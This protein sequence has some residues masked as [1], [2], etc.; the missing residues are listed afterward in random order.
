MEVGGLYLKY[1]SVY[2]GMK[3]ESVFVRSLLGLI[4][5]SLWAC[6]ADKTQGVKEGVIAVKV[7]EELQKGSHNELADLIAGVDI[8]PLETTDSSLLKEPDKLVMDE[9]I[10]YLNRPAKSLHI[11]DREGKFVKALP[12]GRGPGEIYQILDFQMDDNGNLLAL[13]YENLLRYSPEGDYL[14]EFKLLP[15]STYDLNV[16]RFAWLGDNHFYLWQNGGLELEKRDQETYYHLFHM[17]G[18]Q[19]L[20]SNLEAFS[21][22]MGTNRFLHNGENYMVSPTMYDNSI[23]EIDKNGGLQHKYEID[24]GNANV[25]RNQLRPGFSREVR[26][27]NFKRISKFSMGISKVYELGD[28]LYFQFVSNR[29]F[30]F[31]LYHLKEGTVHSSSMND[32][33]IDDQLPFRIIGIDRKEQ[34][35]LAIAEP[36]YL[37]AYLKA[38]KK[39]L[40]ESRLLNAE[41]VR[42][43]NGLEETDNPVLL[44]LS[45]D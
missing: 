6:E 38:T 20:G 19:L 3:M 42:L 24:F 26:D 25:D 34:K 27:S 4:I 23:Y 17:K 35:L 13:E 7:P 21:W 8:I 33:L 32:A 43:L 1:R 30:R 9:F 2:C 15:D 41:D 28:Y 14:D 44:R 29:Q 39:S 5:L 12:Q 37:L 31:V 36:P 11:F 18:G 45:L 16:M 40:E 10:Y 22:T